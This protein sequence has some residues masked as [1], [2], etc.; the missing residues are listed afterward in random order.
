MSTREKLEHLLPYCAIV[1][2]RRLSGAGPA[3]WGWH[4]QTASGDQVYLGRSPEGA[5]RQAQ[6][7]GRLWGFYWDP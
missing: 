1:H 4:A 7:M 2:G 3:R 6:K 5:V